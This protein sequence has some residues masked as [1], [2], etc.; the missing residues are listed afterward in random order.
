MQYMYVCIYIYI[1][2]HTHTSI[3]YIQSKIIG[4]EWNSMEWSEV[5]YNATRC[6]APV[7]TPF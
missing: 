7:C 2:R 4:W 6:D 3:F 1:H 5:C